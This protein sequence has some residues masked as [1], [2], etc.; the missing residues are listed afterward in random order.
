MFSKNSRPTDFKK[1]TK[2]EAKIIIDLGCFEEVRTKP[3]LLKLHS[4]AI[5]LVSFSSLSL[6]L[7]LDACVFA[8]K[9]QN[10][11][12]VSLREKSVSL[13]CDFTTI[14]MSM[15]TLASF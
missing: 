9:H 3:S 2:I 15:S 8:F 14:S 11:D 4:N 13:Y 10:G 12:K 7:S 1:K 5:T 6:S